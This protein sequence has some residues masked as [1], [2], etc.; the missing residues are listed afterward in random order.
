MKGL[1][2]RTV[3][4]AMNY[5]KRSMRSEFSG[6]KGLL[7]SVDPASCLISSLIFLF[8]SIICKNL[9]QIFLLFIVS[10]V[11]A[12]ASRISLMKFLARVLFFIPI[13]TMIVMIPSMFS[14]ITPG[15]ALFS[16]CSISITEE[17]IRK[18]LIFTARVAVAIS[19][20]IAATM[21]VEWD[22]LIEGFRIL[23]IPD[24]MVRILLICYRY[25][26]LMANMAVSM[27][28]SRRARIL[29]KESW[30]TSWNWGSEAVGAL[31]L[32]SMMLSEMVHMAM[33]ARGFGREVEERKR[34]K[35]RGAAFIIASLIISF[36]VVTE[37]WR[38]LFSI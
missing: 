29:S 16:F 36:L 34:I 13:F 23:K 22:D 20:P 5:F 28:T 6:K 17:G 25:T 15:K 30:R 21:A 19:F 9:E 35:R 7:Q 27:L 33:T 18:A 32:K 11:I 12:V 31:L 38:W 24:L 2:E 14:W 4:E 1:A 3:E 10:V 8:T 37:G 26:F